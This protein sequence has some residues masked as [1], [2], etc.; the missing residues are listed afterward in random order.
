MPYRGRIRAIIC[1]CLIL[2]LLT[3]FFLCLT[4]PTGTRYDYG[5]STV[6]TRP[7]RLHRTSNSAS[8]EII[9]VSVV[10]VGQESSNEAALL[11]KSLL[12]FRHNPIR[13]HFLVDPTARHILSTLMRTSHLY[14]IEYNFYPID[15]VSIKDSAKFPRSIFNL[16]DTLPP[17]AKKVVSLNSVVLLSVDIYQ[18]WKLFVDMGGHGSVLGLPVSAGPDGETEFNSDVM[19]VDLQAVREQRKSGLWQKLLSGSSEDDDSNVS[20]GLGYLYEKE[21]ALIY[22]LHPGWSVHTGPGWDKTR[23]PCYRQQLTCAYSSVDSSSFRKSVHEYDG[24]LLR[25]KWI[26]CDSGP[27]FDKNARDYRAKTSV[28][29][30]PCT[31]LIREGRQERRTHLFYTGHFVDP[32]KQVADDVTLELHVTL[33]R[34]VPMLEPMCRHWEGPMSIAV[35]ANDSEVS[36]LLDLIHSSSV[37]SSRRNIAYHVVYKEGVNIYYPINSLRA[38]AM[39]NA[40]TQYVF[41]NDMDF[42]PSFGLYPLLKQTFKD[43]DLSHS[44]LVVP[45]FETYEDLKTHR[46][47]RSKSALLNMVAQKTVFQFHRKSYIRGHAPTNY[48]RWSKAAELYEIQWQPQFEPFLV[49]SK[50]VTPL[51][52]RFVS[53]NYDKE[54]HAETLYYQRVKFYVVADGF[55]LHLPHALSRDARKENDR[56]RECYIRRRDEWRAERVQEYGYEPYLVNVYKIW[57]WLSSPYDTS[58]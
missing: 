8:C 46:F 19:L 9:D 35:F 37:I 50:N 49:V 17:S 11:V 56:H 15:S 44:V 53:R 4:R 12:L 38:V 36:S 22:P 26:D 57:N 51:D 52:T 5:D 13:L 48:P 58:L 39:E 1:S 24:N 14:G 16:A 25:E 21:P 32:T 2:F 6:A 45:A 54:S 31:D 47:P 42:L 55:L 27:T 30:P 20:K 18:L 23:V 28:F 40:A 41:L 33:D 3:V 43:C 29:T 34:L 7:G 10:V